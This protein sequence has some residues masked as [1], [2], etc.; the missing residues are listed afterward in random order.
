MA[1]NGAQNK[2]NTSISYYFAT[3]WMAL[4][5]ICTLVYKQK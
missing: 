2:V 1:E 4:I 5:L 3:L